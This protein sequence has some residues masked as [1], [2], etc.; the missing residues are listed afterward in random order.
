MGQVTLI[1]TRL[2]EAGEEFVYHGE[3]SGCDGCPYRSQCL[4]LS[5]GVKYEITSVRD[6][7]Q[8]L[9][10]AMHD[11]GVQAVEVEPAAVRAN[12]SARNAYAGSKVTL[13]GPCPHTECPSHEFCEPDGVAFEEEHR[14]DEI[15]GEPPHDYC[16]LDRDLT[17]VEFAPA[18]E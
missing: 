4:N 15:V 5:E 1:G 14:I 13:E 2:A 3:A 18:D 9:D 8:V 12:V 11:A 10:C 6:N 17:L 7:A 16:M